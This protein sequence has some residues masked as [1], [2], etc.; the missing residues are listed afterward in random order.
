MNQFSSAAQ[1]PSGIRRRLSLT[2]ASFIA[3]VLVVGGISLGLA[4]RIHTTNN[5]VDREN[6]HIV[7]IG[8]V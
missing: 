5:I 1:F 4:V 7:I 2:F 6:T 8:Q 3:I